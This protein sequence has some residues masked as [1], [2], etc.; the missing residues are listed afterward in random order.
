MLKKKHISTQAHALK[1][2]R[3]NNFITALLTIN[4]DILIGVTPDLI[5]EL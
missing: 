3:Y 2:I 4:D 5:F 1:L